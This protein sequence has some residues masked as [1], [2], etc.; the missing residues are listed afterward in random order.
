MENTI[1]VD[2]LGGFPIFLETPNYIGTH[3]VSD[4]ISKV[5]PVCLQNFRNDRFGGA[6]REVLSLHAWMC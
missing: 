5:K 4:L 3:L 1:K 6:I 2:D